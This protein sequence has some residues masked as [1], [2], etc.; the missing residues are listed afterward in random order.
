VYWL[1]RP[2]YLRWAAAVTIVVA[3]LLWDLR[4]EPTG[5][6]PFTARAVDAGEGLD[7]TTVVWQEI[8]EGLLP[9]VDLAG[10]VAAVPLKAG[11]PITPGML[12]GGVAVPEGWFT[13]PLE[14]GGHA[15]AGDR[16]VLLTVDGSVPGIVVTPQQGDRYGMGST[17]AVVA[18]PAEHTALVADAAR[19]GE[20]IAAVSP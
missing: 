16:L 2:P 18:V 11:E 13:L 5:P 14:V 9:P 6:H 3:A 10:A 17:P 19:R 1:Q 12:A 7:A 4:S 15:G 20:V 8:P